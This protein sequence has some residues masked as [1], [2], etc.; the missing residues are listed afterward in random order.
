VRYFLILLALCVVASAQPNAILHGVVTDPSDAAIPGATVIVTGPDGSV[1]TTTADQQGRYSIAGLPPGAYTVRIGATGFTLFEKT[2]VAL[3]P[4]QSVGLDAKLT[5]TLE[6][7]E[8]T[9][10]AEDKQTQIST[11]PANNAGALVLKGADLDALSDDPDDLASDL[12]A[13]A[14]PAA[15][16][17][18]GQIFID[19]FSGGR[20]PPKESIREIRIN[21]N[22]FA[23]EYDR[24]GF[25][26]IEIFTKP[27]TDK[28]RGQAFMN[29]GDR[30]FNSRNPFSTAPTQPPYQSRQF[31]GNISGPLG[32]KASFFFDGEERDIDENALIV[33]SVLDPSLNIVPFNSAIVTPIRRM[34]VSPRLDYQLNS[35][36]T[37]TARYTYSDQTSLNQGLSQFS[38][39]TRAYSFNNTEQTVQLTET[40][41]LNARTI[42]ETRFQYIRS[43]GDQSGV[44]NVPTINVS[45]A[46]TSGGAPFSLNFTDNDTYEL[47][48]YT[49]MTHGTHAI[50]FGAR[51]REYKLNSQ[52]TSNFNGT[53]TF[54]GGRF[55]V[56]TANNQIQL[57]ASGQQVLTQLQSIAVY[58]Q[59]QLLLNQG[60]SPAQVRSLGYGPNQFTLNGGTPL[61]GVNQFDAGLFIQD[62][63]RLRPNLTVSAGLRYEGQTNISDHFDLAP[64]IGIA[65][66]PGAA[67]ATLR[68]K[69][70]I[71]GGFGIFYDRFNEDLTLNS[72]RY[73]GVTEQQFVVRNPDF[74][75]NVPSIAS[76]SS[77]LQTQAVYK[78]D[79]HLRAPYIMQSAI[80]IERQLPKNITLSLNYTNSR[81]LHNLRT[82]NINAPLPG[83]YDPNNPNSSG[84]RPFGNTAGDIYLYESSGVFKQNQLLTSV[85]A[86]VNPRISLFGFYSLSKANSNT[87]S[88]GTFPANQ[89]DLS[90]EY[91]RAGF[92]VRNRAF[93]GGSMTGPYA[94]SLSPFI[95]LAS[96]A[97]FNITA[98]RDLNGDGLFTDRPAFATDLSRPSVVHTAF[99]VF[100]TN[101]LPGQTI[102]PRNYGQSPGVISINMRLSRTWGFGERR[103]SSASG[104]GGGGSGGPG[105]GRGP[106]GGGGRG[107]GPPGGGNMGFGG[108]R[109]GGPGGMFGGGSSGKRYSLTLSINSRNVI[110]HVNLGPRI[111]DLS[112]PFFG[113]SISTGGGFGPGGGGGGG[114]AGNRK[115]EFMLRFSF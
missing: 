26:R 55:P 47:Q 28:F 13:L 77:A 25:G 109:G 101:P 11:D 110:N 52:S 83:T 82:R 57:D 19:G 9:V 18:G 102:I 48:N 76:L 51:L 60:L 49:S 59:T 113:Q 114:A 4:G 112:S 97:P 62:D 98:G 46:F 106:G 30:I 86:R 15:G 35:N 7:Q 37:L 50:K 34:T 78:V 66:A 79:S 108:P 40:A 94:I 22:P 27:G 33:A 43:R 73:N 12:Q 107:G 64:R 20:L 3:S 32:K 41:V 91:G 54:A 17:N 42:N 93:I 29:F 111:G 72:I 5:V 104:S 6:K 44:S 70:V 68:P 61:A 67:K 99:G 10:N 92:D 115:L 38:L 105:G 36:N 85:Q 88:V 87:D 95:M 84:V 71:R 96:G 1:K 16:P 90:T 23:A 45:G 58:R 56:L 75:P 74:Y 65:W 14:G 31:G 2:G 8:V 24:L 89:Y 81:G 80:G 63:W 100:D 69:M 103:E 21:S 39:P 53:F